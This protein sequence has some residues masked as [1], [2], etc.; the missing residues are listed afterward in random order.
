MYHVF[1]GTEIRVFSDTGY[2]D[3]GGGGGNGNGNG[4][5]HGPLAPPGAAG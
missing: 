1:Q 4:R 2:D 5:G 3:Y